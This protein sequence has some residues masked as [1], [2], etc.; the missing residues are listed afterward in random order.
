MLCCSQHSFSALVS[1]RYHAIEC[2]RERCDVVSGEPKLDPTNTEIVKKRCPHGLQHISHLLHHSAE[3]GYASFVGPCH[4]ESHLP[5]RTFL[6]TRLFGP[7]VSYLK[8]LTS[9]PDFPFPVRL[10]CTFEHSLEVVY[11]GPPQRTLALAKE[12]K[13][14]RLWFFG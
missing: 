2:L 11:S 14:H 4:V 8:R 10:Q 7:R 9:S 3:E 13:L 6:K 12:F 5:G 1:V